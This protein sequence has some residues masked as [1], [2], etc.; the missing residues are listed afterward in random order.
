[1]AGYL[2]YLGIMPGVYNAPTNVGNIT[3]YTLSNLAAGSNYYCAVTAYD[4]S[5]NESLPSN[6]VSV[7]ITDT[8]PPTIPTGL[9]A[10][11]SSSSTVALSWEPSTDNGTVAGYQ[12]NRNYIPLASTGGTLSFLDTSVTSGL[13]YT[14]TVQAF[15]EVGN[16]SSPSAPVSLDVPSSTSLL[17][18]SVVGSGTV[19]SSPEGLIC[20]SGT[21]TAAYS[22]GSTVTLTAQSD[23]K[24]KFSGWSGA[25]NGTSECIIQLL[26]DQTV[27][28]TFSNGRNGSL[29]GQAGGQKGGRKK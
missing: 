20:S 17:S 11:L 1:M 28:A 13:A 15:D 12:L 19:T 25:C 22:T 27:T 24:W 26:T 14:Y 5:G 10:T 16:F 29:S 9:T 8:T 23:K 2:L 6:E 18:V 21:C 4:E 7:Y 3:Q